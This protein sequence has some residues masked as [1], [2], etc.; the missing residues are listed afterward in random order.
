MQSTHTQVHACTRTHAHPQIHQD[1]NTAEI[2]KASCPLADLEQCV[3]GLETP[4]RLLTHERDPGRDCRPRSLSQVSV[5][6]AVALLSSPLFY[7]LYNLTPEEPLTVFWQFSLL[8]V[9]HEDYFFKGISW[10]LPLTS[11]RQR[12]TLLP[13]ELLRTLLHIGDP[14]AAPQT[15][16]GKQ[17]VW[18]PSVSS[19]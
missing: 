9:T 8:L 6:V 3:N 2:T 12:G 1:K 18:L 13:M 15:L 11:T 14:C 17:T 7:F 4:W 16:P 19:S 10:G 5:S